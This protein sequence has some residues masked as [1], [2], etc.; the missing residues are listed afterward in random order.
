[1]KTITYAV[2]AAT[3]DL[4]VNPLLLGAD[5][6]ETVMRYNEREGMFSPFIHREHDDSVEVYARLVFGTNLNAQR[7]KVAQV[8]SD[9]EKASL[10][11]FSQSGLISDPTPLISMLK[12]YARN[13][14]LNSAAYRTL[15]EQILVERE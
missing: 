8:S 5:L 12:G 3:I 9:D 11:I 13:T 2:K 14:A 15:E 10:E 4:R 1:M 6:A 7:V